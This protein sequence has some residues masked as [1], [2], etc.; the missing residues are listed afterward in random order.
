[1]NRSKQRLDEL[2]SRQTP[3]TEMA[4]TK[5]FT[6]TLSRTH[7]GG[8]GGSIMGE[9]PRITSP[10]TKG[11]LWGGGGNLTLSLLKTDVI[12]RR[13]VDR[14]HFSMQDLIEA[15]YSEENKDLNDMP[16]AGMTRPSFFSLVKE[17][18]RYNHGLWSEVYPFPCQKPVGQI[19]V[20]SPELTDAPQ[21]RATQHM[22]NG[23][24][25]VTV[26]HE[27]RRLNARYLLG[28]KRN[29]TAVE[30]DYRNL[31]SLSLRL[32][33]GV[34]QGHRRYMDEDGNYLKVVQYQPADSGKPLE[35]YDFE[36]DRDVNG[37]FEPPTCGTDGRFFWVHQV[38]PAEKT[39]PE[40]FRYVM[41]GMVSGSEADTGVL[42]PEKGLGSMPYIER[43][44]QGMLKVPH[45][46]TMTHPEIFEIMAT[47]Y[48]YVSAAP[49]VAVDAK[50]K[51]D[52]SKSGKA[53]LYV[54]VVTLNEAEDYMEKAKELL[55]EAE[56]LD[57]EGIAAEN[58]QWYGE[59]YEKRE[60]GRILLGKTEQERQSGADI[61][62][63][64][65]YQSWTSGH[66]GYCR[67]DPSRYEGS[68][69]Y[70]C[71][72]VDTQSWH[73]LPCYNELFTEGPYFMRNQYEP[74]IQWPQLLTHWH[75]TLKEKA[76]VKFGLPG[77][78]IAHGY[79]PAAAQSPWY[80]ENGVLDFTTEVPGQIM[81]VLWNFWDY[82][83]DEDF[84]RTTLYP[85]LKDLAIFYEAFARRGWDGKQFN[86]EPTVE[87]ESYGISYRLEYTRNATGSLALF[88]KTL[89]CAAEA[90]AY[91][92]V[93]GDCI[94][95]WKEV[96]ENLAPYPTFRVNGGEILGG[97]EKAF[98][99]FT[100]G[101][102]F[103][104][105]G[106]YPVN[107]A[108]EINL[109]SPQELK[110]LA[111]RTADVVT[112]ARNWEPYILTGASRDYVPCRYGRGAV[113]IDNYGILTQDIVEAPER[114]MNSRSGRIHLF[115]AVPEWTT[116]AFRDFLARGGF[117]VSAARDETGVFAVT[118]K[119]ARSLE[120]KL[121]N[122]WPG[123]KIAVTDAETG[124]EVPCSIDRSNGE[125]ICFA[126]EKGHVY[127]IDCIN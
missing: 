67:P 122:P 41:M 51:L 96:A 69:S 12:D 49:G 74:K 7:P 19:I 27:D 14:E 66:M 94:S 75:E 29:I 101:D 117:A 108:D 107:L 64:E 5:T 55:L 2:F 112:G 109:D 33:R 89:L 82:T 15:A 105:T 85:L 58:E 24:T 30:L 63:D 103:M 18:G 125:C 116:A 113:K 126:A 31:D 53:K 72:D 20:K 81:K 10:T 40:G 17:G 76:R 86:L 83:G 13:Y 4:K 97:N 92:G 91:L 21:P 52:G 28:M 68:A 60:S 57:F 95:G 46:R 26:S 118:V 3:L 8:M 25:D 73:S 77:M 59:L 11:A 80:M 56:A 99:R 47:N 124:S 45:I 70:A 106:Y 84:L 54:A 39:F 100:R 111:T 1:M 114:L 120:C 78:Y 90:A 104:F 9:Y 123:A 65:T 127:S 98:P 119:A 50:I 43:D 62:F 71:Y 110:D 93:D 61:L 37:L 102:H 22:K 121:M 6:R 38:F 42:G 35:Y 87:T 79:L 88:R 44:S 115:P 23:V 16:L 32:Y 34:D 36:R 48:S